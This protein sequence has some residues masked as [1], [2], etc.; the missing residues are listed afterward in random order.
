MTLSTACTMLSAV[1]LLRWRRSARMIEESVGGS[2]TAFRTVYEICKM[3]HNNSKYGHQV[4]KKYAP[5]CA[6]KGIKNELAHLTRH[7]GTRHALNLQNAEYILRARV[8]LIE[9]IT[10]C[11]T[12]NGIFT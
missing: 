11:G 2:A 10:Q 9:Y 5:W 3:F 4:S 7:K 12:S 8:D 6:D 1:L